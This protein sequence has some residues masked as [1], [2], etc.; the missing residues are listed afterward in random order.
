MSSTNA[1][2]DYSRHIVSGQPDA[3]KMHL[4]IEGMRCASCAWQIENTLACNN[5]VK[6]RI[7]FSTRRLSI[8]WQGA[9][10]RIYDLLHQI[11]DLG[12]R[13]SPFDLVR[14]ESEDRQ[15]QKFLLQCMAVA[16][17]ASGNI[18][19]LSFALWFSGDMGGATRDLLHWLSALVGLPAVIYAGRPFY[20]SAF[21]ALKRG[22][23]NMDVPISLAIVLA[24]AMSLLETINHGAY[25][26]F[27]SAVMLV[28]L[29]LV[30]RYLDKKARGKARAAAEDLLQMLQGT[31]T[32]LQ[33]GKSSLMLA[34]D[35]KPGMILQ[36]AVGERII[37]DGRV[38]SGQSEIDPS[39]ITGETMPQAIGTG[40]Q[41]FA[42]AINLSQPIQIEVTAASENSLLSDI[43]R[44]ME[45]AEQAQAK[46]VRLADRVAGFYTPVVHLLAA[47][48][49]LGWWLGG[50]LAW[51]PSLL[52][53]TTVL[54]ITC[55]CAL[56]LAV[57]AVQVM[58]SQNLFRRGILLKSGDAL[59][60][61][62]VIDTIIFDKTGTLTEGQAKLIN[63]DKI[64]AKDLQLAASMATHSKHPLSRALA[65]AWKGDLIPLQ[66][67]EV[68]GSG[69][70]A[71]YQGDRIRLG[72]AEWCGAEIPHH[73]TAMGIFLCGQEIRPVQFLFADL[74]RADAPN[75]I[76]ELKQKFDIRLLSGDRKA[77][78]QEIAAKAG[79][80]QWQAALL[81]PDK[82]KIV[83][84]LIAQKHKVLM[85]GDG[86]NDAASLACASVSMSPSTAMDITQNVA[87]VV[88]QGHLLNP[89]KQTIYIAKRSAALV[90][91]NF[92][93]S[94]LYN[95]IAIPLA[96][97]GQVTPLIAT[98]AMSSSSIIVVLNA[99]RLGMKD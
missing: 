31:A 77:V 73:E 6:A 27:D 38:I 43:V 1:L 46:Y 86:L 78:V 39:L 5:N 79:I 9:K 95:V 22:R 42:G 44:L 14:L 80:E 53:A 41:V 55:P 4:M 7:N 52:I 75:I 94:F 62:A 67:A 47:A 48:A 88:F 54:I 30:G 65:S 11:A 92:A 84:D 98:L 85:I 10:D 20:Y 45:N 89:V 26:Y 68:P 87:D 56:A 81:P 61:L 12:F 17:F 21:G 16:G 91:Q 57:P 74:L 50:G 93:L 70:E 32:V 66:V 33:D 35:L 63:A 96:L 19:L 40:S 29:L 2:P 76:A 83:K 72:K 99:L 18:M 71:D 3:H 82:T 69:L 49:F 59:E 90:R 8:E 51:Q 60:R 97:M 28:F 58:A 23:A 13:F 34:Q 36:I 64:A 37:A 25:I 24:C 15:E